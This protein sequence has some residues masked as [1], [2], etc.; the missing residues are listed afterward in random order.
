MVKLYKKYQDKG[1]EIFS[2]SLDSE[3]PN[4][5]KAIRTDN[6][7]WTNVIDTRAASGN[8]LTNTWNVQYLPYTMLL[9]REGKLHAIDPDKG[10]VESLIKKLL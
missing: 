8:A 2:V 7:T 5:K 3:T 1:F 9:D 10:E 6:M 4:W